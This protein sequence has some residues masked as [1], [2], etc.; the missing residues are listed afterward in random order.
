MKVPEL[1]EWAA[2]V[3]ANTEDIKWNG[4][5]SNIVEKLKLERNRIFG[6]R[7]RQAKMTDFVKIL[8]ADEGGWLEGI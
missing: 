5:K 1:K 7:D 2:K 3:E 4:L 6:T 8:S